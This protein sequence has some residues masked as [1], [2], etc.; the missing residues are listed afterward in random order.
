MRHLPLALVVLFIAIC[1]LA[2]ASSKKVEATVTASVPESEV[3]CTNRSV[4]AVVIKNR[5]ATIRSL[6]EMQSSLPFVVIETP[7]DK[8]TSLLTISVKWPT[9]QDQYPLPD[10][11]S[12][13]A[14]VYSTLE[15]EIKSGN[16]RS[17]SARW[18]ADTGC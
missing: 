8:K 12:L 10:S 3:N 4:R 18:D 9:P 5:A 7:L 15:A 2:E 13:G 1:M 6:F 11:L 14:R 17:I 16:V